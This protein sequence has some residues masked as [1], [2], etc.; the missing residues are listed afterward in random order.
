MVSGD[1]HDRAAG[2]RGRIPEASRFPWTT[3]VGAVKR[4][5]SARRLASA[6]DGLPGRLQRKGQAQHARCAVAP[7]V[8]DD[9]RARGAAAD[10]ERQLVQP[11]PAH[12]SIT[13]IQATWSCQAGAGGGSARDP[14]GLLDESHGDA[15]RERGIL[16][17]DEI[18]GGDSVSR[19]VTDTSA[20][21]GS[22][23]VDV[24]MGRPM[25]L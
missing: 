2:G 13:V 20:A 11:A 1:E 14:V 10:D 3:S 19:A 5:S 17:C 12:S 9:P 8:A 16:R 18:G 24:D 6:R 23:I 4:S 15:H 7:P 22:A 21:C 25:V